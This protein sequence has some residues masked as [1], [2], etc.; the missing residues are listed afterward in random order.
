[1]DLD[2]LVRGTDPGPHQTVSDPP[3]L[4]QLF[5]LAANEKITIVPLGH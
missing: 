1:M 5:F 4:L 2:P 3:H